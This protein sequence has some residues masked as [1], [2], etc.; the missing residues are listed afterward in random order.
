V[1]V[2]WFRAAH[3][4]L[5]A[6]RWAEL[7]KAAKYA[8]SS[9]G[10]T[11]AQLFARAM[12]GLETR[13]VLVKR[14]DAS[15]HQDS[16]RALGLLPLADG[17]AGRDDVL[18]R[19]ERLQEF[20]REARKFGSQRQASE[21]RAAAIGL[22]NLARTAGFRDP[23]RLQWAMEQRAVADLAHGP[24]VVN[25][26]DV[27]FELSIDG[28]G[29]PELSVKKNGKTLKTLP[30]SLKKDADVVELKERLQALKRQ[31][32]RVRDVLEGAMCRGDMFQSSELPA[33]MAHP[34]LAPAL[35][36]IV[37]VGDGIAGYLDEGGHV[38][39]DYAGTLHAIGGHEQLRIA[40]PFDLFAQ[41]TWSAWQ[42]ECFRAER[43][44]P[45]KQLFRELYPLT[46]SERG[47][48]RTSRYA[49]HQANP[50]QA[51]ALLGSR[52]WVARAEEGVTRTFHEK[53]L[54]ARLSFEEAFFTPADIEGLTLDEV[55][56]TK[57]GEWNPIPLHEIP[58]TLFSETMRDLD[59]VVS[60]A[61]QG[62][63]DPEAT[64]ATVEMRGSLVAETCRL[65]N[66]TNV[67]VKSSHAIVTGK[68][69]SYSIH[70]GSAG[71][72]LVPG[73]ALP[74]VAVHSQ[75]RGRLFLPFA[76]DDPR[77]AEVLSKVLLLARDSEIRDPSILKWIQAAERGSFQ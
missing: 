50:R 73:T 62:G 19:Y 10:H 14:I 37:F 42:R 15:R 38:L 76:D 65:L 39:R 68:L 45:F 28:A 12:T 75:H 17:D 23:Q 57:K 77:T 36:R 44:Q 70:L 52:G 22:E 24:L 54:T 35:S 63:V 6:E 49:G 74:I 2:E 66:L 13:E 21:K 67:E 56:F 31:K 48:E 32:S 29:V 27:T 61:H 43:I 18:V 47:R 72:M 4:E 11:R 58:A 71:A 53:G 7:D 20:I 3:R 16:V 1:D 40:H 26:G 5:G 69:G 64:A 46:E 51:L 8:A 60:V 41:T 9:A 55:V 33:L 30:S 34:I 25:K 59:L